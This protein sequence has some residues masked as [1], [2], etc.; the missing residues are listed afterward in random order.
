MA[1]IRINKVKDFTTISNGIMR[2]YRISLKAKGLLVFMLSRPNDWDFSIA[3]M[4][5]CLPDSERAIKNALRELKENGYVIVR[6]LTPNQTKSK[7]FEYI[8]DVYEEPQKQEGQNQG[9]ENQGVEKQHLENQGL[10][11]QGVE[12]QGLENDL[13]LNTELLNTELLNTKGIPNT[14]K[15]KGRFVAPTLDEVKDYVWEKQLNVDPEAFVD[16]FTANGWKV[17]GKAPMKDWQAAAR[18]W[19]KRHT[20]WQAQNKPKNNDVDKV[21]RDIMEGRAT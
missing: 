18:S 14:D 11:K 10:E 1:I 4:M 17:G 19:S 6:K 15:P 13:Q 21:L 5:T 16:H 20:E 3:G 12:N 9:V 8:Y 2:D 7:R